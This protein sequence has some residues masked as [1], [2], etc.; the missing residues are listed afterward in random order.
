MTWSA[1]SDRTMSTFL[2]LHTPVTSAS[3]RLGDLHGEGPHASHQSGCTQS[4]NTTGSCASP[5][6]AVFGSFPVGLRRTRLLRT[7]VNSGGDGE[8][9]LRQ[10][11]YAVA[12]P[13][14]TAREYV[15]SQPAPVYEATQYSSTC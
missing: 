6:W 5:K 7:L 1:P 13:D 10:R 9:T 8:V 3:K 11:L 4:N 2:A 12:G 14:P 15:S